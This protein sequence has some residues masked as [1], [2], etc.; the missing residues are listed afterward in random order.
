MGGKGDE[1][2]NFVI[3]G[4]E[5]CNELGRVFCGEFESV[6]VCFMR[7]LDRFE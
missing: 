7:W 3:Y 1:G 2:E 6:S 5:W 4:F